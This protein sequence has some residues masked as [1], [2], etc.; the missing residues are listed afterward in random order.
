MGARQLLRFERRRPMRRL[1]ALLQWPDRKRGVAMMKRAFSS[2]P[3]SGE[4]VAWSEGLRRRG[5]LFAKGETRVKRRAQ[6]PPAR[7]NPALAPDARL[8][9]AVEGHGKDQDQ[10][11]DN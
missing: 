8:Q 2:P 3:R 10:A 11:D 1:P 7:V 5:G 4:E 9:E 6:P